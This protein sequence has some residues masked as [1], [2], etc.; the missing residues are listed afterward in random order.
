VPSSII[1]VAVYQASRA[2]MISRY[3]AIVSIRGKPPMRA[4]ASSVEPTANVVSTEVTAAFS[5]L[6]AT[7]PAQV[8]AASAT[9]QKPN[10]V[11]AFGSPSPGTTCTATRRR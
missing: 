1:A 3:P 8:T 5:A 6:A 4:M 11:A 9:N 2:E 10:A 7:A